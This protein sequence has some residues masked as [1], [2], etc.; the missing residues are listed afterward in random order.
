MSTAALT[1]DQW[2]YDPD[3]VYLEEPPLALSLP[4]S[5]PIAAVPVHRQGVYGLLAI[6]PI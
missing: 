3:H 6:H 4:D 5:L 2:Q 1:D